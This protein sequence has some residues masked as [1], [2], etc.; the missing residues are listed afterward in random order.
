MFYGIFECL[1]L[2]TGGTGKTALLPELVL[3]ILYS[4]L[5]RNANSNRTVLEFGIKT[6]YAGPMGN[7]KMMMTWFYIFQ[8]NCEMTN[9]VYSMAFSQTDKLEFTEGKVV[10]E[11][12]I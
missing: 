12:R 4:G 5:K 9:I 1:N 11:N 8:R 3:L 10:Y 2:D 6:K 7:A